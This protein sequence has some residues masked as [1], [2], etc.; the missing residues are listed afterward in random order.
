MIKLIK[1]I[2]ILTI[3]MCQFLVPV[4]AETLNLN[5]GIYASERRNWLDA[6]NVPILKHLKDQLKSE[7]NLDVKIKT[8]F[9]LLFEQ[10][11]SHWNT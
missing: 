10:E 5:F 9:F 1:K 4:Y 3:L 2:S 6:D 8:V 11:L 7:Y